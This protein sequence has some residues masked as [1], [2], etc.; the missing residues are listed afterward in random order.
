MGAWRIVHPPDRIGGI[1]TAERGPSA[2]PEFGF[3]RLCDLL[4][5]FVYKA[6]RRIP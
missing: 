5:E 6:L 2:P 4:R 1:V 3:L